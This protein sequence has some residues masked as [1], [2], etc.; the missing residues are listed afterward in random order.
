MTAAVI[1]KSVLFSDNF[2]IYKNL[3]K[4]KIYVIPSGIPLG[5]W[6]KFIPIESH[7][8][9]IYAINNRECFAEYLVVSLHWIEVEAGTWYMQL[10]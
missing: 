4:V 5:T 9:S 8:V 2:R 3:L 6:S 7:V 10:M 1:T